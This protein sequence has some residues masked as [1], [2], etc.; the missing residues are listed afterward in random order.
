V[1]DVT[2]RAQ[3]WTDDGTVKGAPPGG[4]AAPARF[5]RLKALAP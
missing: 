3:S 2:G 4:P 5:Y 1:T